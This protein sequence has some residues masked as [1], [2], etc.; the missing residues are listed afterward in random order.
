MKESTTAV[1]KAKEVYN[2]R[3]QEVEK[4]KK[5]NSPKDIEKAESKLKKHQDDYKG[6]VEKHNIIKMEF[7]KKMTSTCRVGH[8]Q[9][10][11]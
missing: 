9:Y 6:L 3:Q 11:K 2:S 4:I 10:S 5:D 1:Q 7:E 8:H